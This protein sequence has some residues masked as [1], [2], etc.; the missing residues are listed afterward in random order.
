MI[1]KLLFAFFLV[2]A[3]GGAWFAWWYHRFVVDDPGPQ[4]TRVAI[5]QIIAQ[6]S[7][8]TYRDGVTPLG[9]F[10]DQA[11]RRYVPYDELPQDWIDAIVASEDAN[12]W[13]HPGFD[14]KHI[15]RAVFQNLQ[16]GNVVAG[17]S[18]L[19]Q[20]TAV[21]ARRSGRTM[22]WSKVGDATA[23]VLANSV[24]QSAANFRLPMISAAQPLRITA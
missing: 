10:F 1:R 12:F 11:H 3:L 17:G 16:A 4:F 5:E 20:Q 8:V 13:S 9:V 6:E 7:P 22:L 2:A 15:V 19:T 21:R 18:T 24:V 23:D 14:P